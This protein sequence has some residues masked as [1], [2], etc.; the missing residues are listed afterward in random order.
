MTKVLFVDWPGRLNRFIGQTPRQ[1]I[2][3]LL[4]NCSVHYEKDYFPNLQH[5][6]VEYLPPNTTSKAQPLDAGMIACLSQTKLQA[7]SFILLA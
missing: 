6:H 7:S 4:D 3:L 5:V 2:F 1:E